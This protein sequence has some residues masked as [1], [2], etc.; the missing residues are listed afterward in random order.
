M[1]YIAEKHLSYI[2]RGRKGSTSWHHHITRVVQ[3]NTLEFGRIHYYPHQRGFLRVTNA[4]VT[5]ILCRRFSLHHSK[6]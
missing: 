1:D 5:A 3:L 6:A 2:L 4:A